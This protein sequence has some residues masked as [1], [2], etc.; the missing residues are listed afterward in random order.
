[1]IDTYSIDN[2][3]ID[4]YL[5]DTEVGVRT[6]Q[7]GPLI[8]M[9]AQ[10]AL[11]GVLA[12]TV[13]IGTAGWVVGILVGILVGAVT[14]GLLA[15]ALHRN[16]CTALGPANAVTLTRATLVGGIAALIAASTEPVGS[17]G[18]AGAATPAMVP[19]LVALCAVALLLDGVDGQVARR[20]GTV[21]AL[22]ARFDMEV[23]AF[24]ILVLSLFV[25]ESFG[26]W[27]LMI[28]AA[29]YLFVAVGALAP[30]MRASLPPRHWRKVVAAVQGVVLT[31]AAA[32]VLP[33]PA[34]VVLLLAALAL[35]GESFGRDVWWLWLHRTAE[36]A[37]LMV[38]PHATVTEPSPLTRSATDPT[39]Q[40]IGPVD[41]PRRVVQVSPARPS[42][43][44]S[45]SNK[46][47]PAARQP[48]SAPVGVTTAYRA[49][50]SRAIKPP[51]ATSQACTPS[52]K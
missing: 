25:A 30:W 13:G 29:R 37:E 9:A 40:R 35:L 52:S 3:L 28:G 45:S 50:A 19:V 7:R 51:A 18:P 26:A 15:R 43:A 48:V 23:D 16:C 6:V 12:A 36:R 33:H 21:S 44:S 47:G 41:G 5:I 38:L 46:A 11:L 42:A 8:G 27:V 34:V 22:G 24:L 1:M 17:V 10:L 39:A 32:Q 20:T 4:T 2:Y 49:P 14:N 31:V